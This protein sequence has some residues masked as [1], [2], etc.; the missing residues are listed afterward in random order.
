MEY[1]SEFAGKARKKRLPST[2][3]TLFV[4]IAITFTILIT[5][6]YMIVS[7]GHDPKD[8]YWAYGMVGT[9]V[10]YWLK[11]VKRYGVGG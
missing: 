2:H 1:N 6:L 10:G 8:K 7:Q 5:C 11:D 4:Q 9:L 3:I